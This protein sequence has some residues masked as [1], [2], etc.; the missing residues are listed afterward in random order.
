MALSLISGSC[1]DLRAPAAGAAETQSVSDDL[2]LAALTRENMSAKCA[3][4]KGCCIRFSSILR[5]LAELLAAK[6]VREAPEVTV[7]ERI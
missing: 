5:T 4:E 2:N 7:Q 6:V 3:H 1:A